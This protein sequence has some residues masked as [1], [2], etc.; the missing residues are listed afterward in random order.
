MSGNDEDIFGTDDY[1]ED[2][3][4]KLFYSADPPVFAA[5]LMAVKVYG[6]S[7]PPEWV[8]QESK[9]YLEQAKSAKGWATVLGKIQARRW[10]GNQDKQLRQFE[11]V[12]TLY[13]D[14]R[15]SG[16]PI[17]KL[18]RDEVAKLVGLGPTIVDAHWKRMN[19]G[20]RY[21]ASKAAEKLTRVRKTNAE[22]LSSR[23]KVSTGSSD[24]EL[25][26]RALIKLLRQRKEADF[27]EL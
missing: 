5:L 1:V 15:R 27:P 2:P 20:R 6:A 23:H 4:R 18:L 14:A 8:I 21:Q 7:G 3:F 19:R 25:Q 10:S 17:N 22:K 9:T 26:Y 24:K 12:V 11:A 16:F 13:E